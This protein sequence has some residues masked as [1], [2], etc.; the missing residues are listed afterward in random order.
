[1]KFATEPSFRLKGS[2][3]TLTTMFI[4]STDVSSLELAITSKIAEAPD[5]FT[6]MPLVVD[7]DPISAFL[8]TK[9]LAEIFRCIRYRGLLPIAVRTQES[10]VKQIAIQLEIA[11][12]NG[13]SQKYQKPD[14][15]KKNTQQAKFITEPVRSGQQVTCTTGDMV[16]MAPVS[17]GAELAAVGNI[18]VYSTLR[19]RAYAGIDG[20]EDAKIFCGKLEAELISIAGKYIVS[21]AIE[22]KYWQSPAM[23]SLN[24]DNLM[25][26]K[27]MV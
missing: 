18:H 16:V 2:F 3:F 26:N 6:R 27:L 25:V 20:F 7:V 24:A 9:K 23:I 22:K 1:M 5:F 4:Q 21:E 12:F 19:G 15:F 14:T 8:T 13:E 17:Q 11:I 10:N